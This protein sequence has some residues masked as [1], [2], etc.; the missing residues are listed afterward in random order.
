MYSVI[1]QLVRVQIAHGIS[2]NLPRVQPDD[3]PWQSELTE[4]RM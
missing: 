4:L 3:V 1:T 2:S